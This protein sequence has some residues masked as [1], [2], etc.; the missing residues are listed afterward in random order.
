MSWRPDDPALQALL[1][2]LT[3]ETTPVYAVGGVVRDHLLGKSEKQTDLDLAVVDPAIP[4]ARRVADRLGWAFYPLDEARDVARLVFPARSANPLVCDIARLRGLQIESDLSSRDFTVN[5]MA[6]SIDRNGHVE[7]I[8]INNGQADLQARR[9]R[10]VTGI[11]LAEDPVRLLR[12]VRFAIQLGF[13]IEAGTREQIRRLAKSVRLASPERVRDELWKALATDRPAAAVDLLHTLGLLINVLPDVA[14]TDGVL[15]SFPHFQDVYGH[16]LRT[17][18]FTAQVRNW[19][20]SDRFTVS[21]WQDDS[22]FAALEPWQT[23]LRRH[24]SHRITSGHMRADW[25]VW[26]ALLHDIGKPATRKVVAKATGGVTTQFLNHEDVGAKLATAQLDNLRFGAKEVTLASTVIKAHMR[27][28]HLYASFAEKPISRRAM[29]R[30][31]RDTGAKQF[32]DPPA[33]D[34]LMLAIAD[35]QA[36]Y[37]ESPPAHWNDYLA[38]IQQVIAFIF[39]ADG[40]PTTREKPLVDGFTLMQ[41]F[42][43]QPGRQIG[44]V[45]ERLM[46]AQIAGEIVTETEALDMA[47]E[48]LKDGDE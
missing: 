21:S 11:S 41:H 42:Q 46:E 12:A 29:Y 43:M 16:T 22:W 3:A 40:W 35:Y 10:R 45:L 13:E 44:Q 33:V 34:T 28:H 1:G 17:L 38:R 27:P 25:L 24:F 6:F 47:S 15:Q 23:Q 26:H 39:D 36:V 37:E 9:L 30:F 31:V 20:T 2:A 5:A 14:G 4:I 8:D 19:L 48:W 32:E 7:L 18:R